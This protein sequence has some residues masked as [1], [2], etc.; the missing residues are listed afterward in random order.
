MFSE[1]SAAGCPRETRRRVKRKIPASAAGQAKGKSKEIYDF[2]NKTEQT[3]S[4]HEED[5]NDEFSHARILAHLLAEYQEPDEFCF[6]DESEPK[7]QGPKDHQNQYDGPTANVPPDEGTA[8]RYDNPQPRNHLNLEGTNTEDALTSIAAGLSSEGYFSS[9]EFGPRLTSVPTTWPL[10]I[11]DQSESHR[12][13]LIDEFL[14][15]DHNVLT[16]Q[17]ANKLPRT[18]QSYRWDE[19]EWKTEIHIKACRKTNKAR[20]SVKQLPNFAGRSMVD[21]STQ[22]YH[23]KTQK[24]FSRVLHYP[25]NKLVFGEVEFRRIS[26]LLADLIPTSNR[27]INMACQH[28]A[29]A[30]AESSVQW[31]PNYPR[32]TNVSSI[33]MAF[34]PEHRIPVEIVGQIIQWVSRADMMNL[35][36][37]NREF[38]MKVSCFVFQSVVVPF[39]PQIYR[40]VATDYHSQASSTS[41]FKGKGKLQATQSN[42]EPYSISYSVKDVVYDGMKVFEAWGSHIRKFAMTFDINQGKGRSFI[43]Y[44]Y[45]SLLDKYT[46]S[47]SFQISKMLTHW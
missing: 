29:P 34:W 17:H 25:S 35:R 13:A 5:G 16:A 41:S 32:S 20:R 2:S 33:S 1:M 21:S 39:R 31:M 42:D 12:R 14:Y 4:G 26:E 45:P 38:E 9:P 19:E 8:L 22:T 36:L 37:V 11:P 15:I 23:T 40:N 6:S 46:R 10:E 7:R 28:D 3:Q 47:V 24:S 27:I 18:S 44:L 30:L 43:F